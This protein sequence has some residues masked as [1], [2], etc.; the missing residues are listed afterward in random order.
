MSY[1][2]KTPL[3]VATDCSGI[4]A[5]IQALKDLK[6]NFEHIWSCEIDKYC[7]ESIKAN[8]KPNIIYDDMTN[9]N[10]K[11]LPNIDAY[12]CGFPCQP[13]SII[14]IKEGLNDKRSNIIVYCINVIKIKT[15]KFFI[16]ENVPHFLKIDNG[17]AYNILLKKL[18][19]IKMYNIYVNMLNSKDYGSAQRRKRL[20][21]I[22]IR[23]DVE[24]KEYET[25]KHLKSKK[26]DDILLDKIYHEN[27]KQSDSIKNIIK[28]KNLNK[29]DNWVI[30]S[31]FNKKSYTL[32]ICPTLLTSNRFFLL[33]YN[34]YL[35]I[36]EK[37]ILQG[38]PKNF[39]KVVCT[40]QLEKQIG[41]S[42]N[43]NVL[44]EIFKE[45]FKCIDIK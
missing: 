11:E 25:P 27:N 26:L 14:G 10:N 20:F 29:K 5:P 4:E 3:R 15:P 41:N 18:K 39:K 9:R 40:S 21:F 33:K 43:V 23:K 31:A 24:K 38:F 45:I 44:K 13:F 19:K 32:D 6:V 42:M 12:I 35:T 7:I 22:G 16:L 30:S 36:E 34:R 28:L 17:N 1:K 8:Y 37:L 2:F